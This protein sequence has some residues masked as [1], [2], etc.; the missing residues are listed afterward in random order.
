MVLVYDCDFDVL[1]VA[2]LILITILN[3]SSCGWENI[4]E[5]ELLLATRQNDNHSPGPGPGRLVPSSHQRAHGNTGTHQNTGTHL[6]LPE[7][8]INIGFSFTY[9]WFYDFI[10]I[11]MSLINMLINSSGYWY[12]ENLTVIFG[13]SASR[14]WMRELTVYINH[15][16]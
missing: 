13:I 1:P 10:I 9:V 2:I 12:K 4:S 5:S 11:C 14:F 3:L 6:Y 7:R 15:I 8:T 16:K